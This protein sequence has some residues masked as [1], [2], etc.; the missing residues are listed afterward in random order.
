M[1]I[2]KAS[3]RYAT[4]LLDLA[5]ERDEV[6]KILED[7]K[8]I[9]N[10]LE[11]SKELVLFLKSPIIKFD[12]KLN[13]LEEIFAPHVQEVTSSFI[14]LLARKNR[15]HLLNQIVAAFIQKYNEYAGIINV[16]VYSAY[17]LSDSQKKE[18][19]QALEEKTRK[20][21][22]MNVTEDASLIG[23]IA[24]RIDDTVIDGT[25]K[26]KLAELEQKYM[27]ATVE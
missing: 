19:H 20:R 12:D 10:T 8:F 2:T 21:V 5:R 18:L 24:V 4:A 14:R 17:T 6:E 27:N 13:A 7:I 26:H 15:I 1:L 3:R 23:G 9:H 22:E 25:V 16:H 11:D